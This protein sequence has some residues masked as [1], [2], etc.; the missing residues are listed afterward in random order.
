MVPWPIALLTLFYGIIA[1]ASAAM[2]WRI[3]G[4][5]VYQPLIWAISWLL[6]SG[7]IMCGLPLLKSWARMLAVFGSVLLTILALAVAGLLAMSRH[8]W[9]ALLATLGAGVHVLVIRYL[10]RPII[11]GYFDG[12]NLLR[13]RR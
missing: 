4:G 11:R 8:P 9:G 6:L 12:E 5:Q 1:A 2:V 13:Q 7:S 10:R 3:L